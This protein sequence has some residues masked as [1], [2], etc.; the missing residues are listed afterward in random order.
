VSQPTKQVC[1]RGECFKEAVTGASPQK[2][3]L[4]FKHCTGE[5]VIN[6]ARAIKHA[7]AAWVAGNLF[8]S[9]NTSNMEIFPSL[10][11]T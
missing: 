3:I 5:L 2:N 6:K 9:V 11:W 4:K 8:L 7:A 10:V 1:A